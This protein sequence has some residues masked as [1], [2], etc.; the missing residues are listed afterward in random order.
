[1]RD[2]TMRVPRDAKT[3]S[4]GVVDKLFGWWVELL[5][6]FGVCVRFCLGA[7][8]IFVVNGTYRSR[9]CGFSSERGD[10]LMEKEDGCEGVGVEV[11]VR[12]WHEVYKR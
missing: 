7:G 12:G 5:V 8:T 11:G 9:A 10:A 2:V 3:Q 6:F 4:Q 1:M